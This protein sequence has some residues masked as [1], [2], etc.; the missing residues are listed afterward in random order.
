[1]VLEGI[2]YYSN[3]YS[4]AT[5]EF[6]ELLKKFVLQSVAITVGTNIANSLVMNMIP[7][8]K[9]EFVNRLIENI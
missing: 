3:I 5:L 2:K 6:I 9:R 1:M 7:K 8:E 4:L